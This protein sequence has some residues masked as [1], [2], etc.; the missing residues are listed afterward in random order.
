M[1]QQDTLERIARNTERTSRRLAVL[2]LIAI[3]WA[4]AKCLQELFT[5]RPVPGG[6]RPG[7]PHPDD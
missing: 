7:G 3:I 6:S 2:E 4:I 1:T 5:I